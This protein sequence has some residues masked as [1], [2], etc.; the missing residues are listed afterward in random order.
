LALDSVAK[1]LINKILAQVM[2]FF[3]EPDSQMVAEAIRVVRG[4]LRYAG[5]ISI[6]SALPKLMKFIGAALNRAIPAA[7]GDDGEDDNDAEGDDEDTEKPKKSDE[8]KKEVDEEYGAVIDETCDLIASL[9][10]AMAGK[11][12]A[13]MNK[14][15]PS[16]IALTDAKEDKNTR[17]QAIGAISE[18]MQGLESACV[19]FL[20]MI[21]P[22]VLSGVKDF[23]TQIGY[24]RNCAFGI[25]VMCLKGG[26]QAHSFYDAAVAALTPIVSLNLA[27]AEVKELNATE[28]DAWDYNP[29]AGLRDNAVSA[30]GK[31]ILVSPKSLKLKEVVPLYIGAL[32]L[33]EDIAES[34]FVYSSVIKMINLFPKDYPAIIEPFFPAIIQIFESVLANKQ[35]SA[36]VKTFVEGAYK[37]LKTRVSGGAASPIP[38]PENLPAAALPPSQASSTPS[39]SLAPLTGSTAVF[40]F[41]TSAGFSFGAAAPASTPSTFSFAAPSSFSFAPGTSTPSG[42]AATAT[43]A[44]AGASTPAPA[45]TTTSPAKGS[46]KK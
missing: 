17:M 46:K 12:E 3:N 15:L 24:A 5:P 2:E 4:V 7:S 16:L 25:G 14:L 26:E 11:F 32:P 41:P 27:S 39:F 29:F 23:R 42:D 43:S 28:A 13:G 37:A 35:T 9:S 30:L 8:E 33:T 18:A 44:A 40:S 6:S 38:E 34:Q 21:F 10:K 1:K 45:A 19:S 36:K 31:M 22:I 20:P